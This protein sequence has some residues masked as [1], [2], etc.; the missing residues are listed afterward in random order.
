MGGS[1]EDKHTYHAASLLKH[2][3]RCYVLDSTDP[4][5]L[6]YICEDMLRRS[7]RDLAATLKSTLI[8]ANM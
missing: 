8:V 7:G 3:P 1:A 5:K 2:G 4:A 6:H